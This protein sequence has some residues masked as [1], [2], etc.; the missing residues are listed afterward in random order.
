MTTVEKGN[1][2][3]D[4]LLK[5]GEVPPRYLDLVRTMLLIAYIEGGRE[6]LR[7]QMALNANLLSERD[8]A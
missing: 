4:H 7:E 5:L 8:A 6:E 2:F 1:A 3:A